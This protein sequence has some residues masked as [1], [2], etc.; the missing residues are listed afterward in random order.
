MDSP[1]AQAT[2]S[3]SRTVLGPAR[4]F[5]V[6]RGHWALPSAPPLWTLFSL[7]SLDPAFGPAPTLVLAPPSALDP[8][9]QLSSAP[10]PRPRRPF[11]ARWP[12]ANSFHHVRRFE[13]Q[14]TAPGSPAPPA[15]ARA[16]ERRRF[17]SCVSP[18]A[19]APSLNSAGPEGGRSWRR[20]RPQKSARARVRAGAGAQGVWWTEISRCIFRGLGIESCVASLWECSGFPRG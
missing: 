3:T 7:A 13:L 6:P 14:R 19:R 12:P 1:S 5:P 10:R 18:W 16:G 20:R 8:A 9:L 2:P 17:H 11:Q 4:F 15:P